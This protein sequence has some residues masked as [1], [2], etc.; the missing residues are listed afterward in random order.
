MI[1]TLGLIGSGAIGGTLARL[2]CAAGLDVVLSNSRGPVQRH[3]A[4]SRVVKAFN[5][6]DF[7]HLLTTARPSGAHDRSAL[8]IAP[9]AEPG[10][11]AP[12]V[13]EHPRGS[14]ARR[15]GEGTDRQ[16]AP[17]IGGALRD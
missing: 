2:A 7:Y 14:G 3:L 15:P 10:R 6:I 12:L 4:G 8:P 16:P 5:N 13:P 17:L 11:G 1:Q 9:G